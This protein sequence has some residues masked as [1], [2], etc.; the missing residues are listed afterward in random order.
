MND[1]FVVWEDLRT[2]M[3]NLVDV[4]LMVRLW[5]VEDHQD[6][7]FLPMAMDLAAEEAL[8]LKVDKAYQRADWK[9]SPHEGKKLCQCPW[10]SI[11]GSFALGLTC[12]FLR[13][14]RSGCGDFP[15]LA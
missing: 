8:G 12:F 13:R 15:S 5:K 7:N 14:R 10:F 11:I 4:G 6:E 9:I 1:A 2:D 3:R